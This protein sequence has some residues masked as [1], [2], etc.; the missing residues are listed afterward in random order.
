MPQETNK[1]NMVLL[2]VAII[3]VCGTIIATTIT[4]IGNNYVERVRQEAELTRIAL[5]SNV[6]SSKETQT[7]SQNTL[8]AQTEPPAS[9]YTVE[10]AITTQPNNPTEIPS[11]SA[12]PECKTIETQFQTFC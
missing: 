11:T 1:S 5:A 6:T 3:G 2:I 4:V 7:V 10:P 12:L 8:I 9:I